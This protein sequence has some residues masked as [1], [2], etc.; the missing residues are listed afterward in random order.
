MPILFDEDGNGIEIDIAPD[1]VKETIQ[2]SVALQTQLQEKETALNEAISKLK[3][4]EDKDLN[5]KKLRDM[6]EVEKAKFTANELALKEQIE[7]SSEEIKSLK[8]SIKSQSIEPLLF[9]YVGD[10]AELKESVMKEYDKL[11]LPETSSKERQE[12]LNRAYII[13]TGGAPKVDPLLSGTGF[14]GGMPATP[15]KVEGVSDELKSLGKSFGLSEE[16]FKKYSK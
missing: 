11:D 5:F 4:F 13:A 8:D 16:D 12:R 10:N 1:K 2:N 9:S 15:S 14:Y 7:K 3:G 6:N